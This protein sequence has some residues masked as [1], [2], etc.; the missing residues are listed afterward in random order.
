MTADAPATV[1]P[2]FKIGDFVRHYRGGFSGRF[3]GTVILLSPRPYDQQDPWSVWVRRED[4]T[5]RH[6]LSSAC[7]VENIAEFAL[8]PGERLDRE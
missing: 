8:A 6:W 7:R 4:G 2:P 5:E 3:A 1:K